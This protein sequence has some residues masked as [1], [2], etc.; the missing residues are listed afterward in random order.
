M[1]QDGRELAVRQWPGQQ[2]EAKGRGCSSESPVQGADC[3]PQEKEDKPFSRN[4]S[5]YTNC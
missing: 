5:D 3:A 2:Y 4:W 1:A